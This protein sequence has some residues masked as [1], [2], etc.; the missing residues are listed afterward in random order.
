MGDVV[1]ISGTI[2]TARDLAHIR[3]KDY[4]ERGKEVPIDFRGAVRRSTAFSQ[5][6]RY[7]SRR[8]RW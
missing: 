5:L 8:V 6:L 1:Y 2:Y 3:I 7:R 4:L